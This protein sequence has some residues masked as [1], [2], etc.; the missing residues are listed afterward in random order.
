M[1][2]GKSKA[3]WQGNLKQ[4]RGK[5]SLG[6]GSFMSS[7]SFGFR[8][9]EAPGTNPEELVG[10]AHAE[11]FSMALAHE[12]DQKGYEPHRVNTEA[13]VELE[14]KDEGFAIT[15]ITLNTRAEVSGVDEESF[16]KIAQEAKKGCPVSK[17]LAGVE[18]KLRA[19]LKRS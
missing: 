14:K 13:R 3:E 19:E 4:G 5:M 17:A 18:I 15:T 10:A 11:C 1:P 7:Y 2:I 8:F 9:E 6:S 16:Q 12:L